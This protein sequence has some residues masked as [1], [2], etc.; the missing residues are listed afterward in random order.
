M[1]DDKKAVSAKL[2]KE[3]YNEIEVISIEKDWS[4]AKTMIF[5]LK[6]GLKK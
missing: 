6:K 5:L 3:L 1:S 2:D 4:I